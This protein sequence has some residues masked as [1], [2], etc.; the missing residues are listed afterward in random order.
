MAPRPSRY[1]G[2]RSKPWRVLTLA[3]GVRD[4]EWTDVQ[5]GYK[6]RMVDRQ[7]CSFTPVRVLKEL[8]GLANLSNEGIE[9]MSGT[10]LRVGAGNGLR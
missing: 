10:T 3:R 6:G 5:T 7:A 8:T 1:A 9:T 2:V 4:R